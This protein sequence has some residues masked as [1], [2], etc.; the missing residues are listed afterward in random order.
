M[1]ESKSITPGDRFSRWTVVSESDRPGSKSYN[2]VCDCGSERIVRKEKLLN[3][4]SRSCGCL[5]NEE[6]TTHG[7]TA[8]A[9]RKDSS[10]YWIWNSMI[11][12]CHNPR[13]VQYPE[14]GG[15]G[16]LVCDEWRTFENFYRDMGPRPSKGHSIDRIDNDAG[17]SPSNCRWA[18]RQE[19][20]LNKRDSRRLTANGVTKC[21]QEW[22][23]DLGCSHATILHRIKAGWTEEEAV[24]KQARKG[25]YRGRI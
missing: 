13:N 17:Y 20:N 15:R 25:N 19:Q 14:Y 4:S 1:A 12:R 22:A 18:T 8:N 23:R 7:L 24:T 2:C 10:E 16:I 11:Q 5:R 21:L 6:L 3:G 9:I